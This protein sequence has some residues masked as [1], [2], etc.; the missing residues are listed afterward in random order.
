MKWRNVRYDEETGT[1]NIGTRHGA[2][3]IHNTGADEFGAHIDDLASASA[4]AL[5]A[6][7]CGVGIPI[8]VSEGDYA[9]FDYEY[10]M[11]GPVSIFVDDAKLLLEVVF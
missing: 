11:P 4:T 5:R 3:V 1:L 2:T 7:L 9:N 10:S 6:A 8:S